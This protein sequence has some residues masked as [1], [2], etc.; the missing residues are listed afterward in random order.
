[1]GNKEST[2]IKNQELKCGYYTIENVFTKDI[3][4]KLKTLEEYKTLYLILEH[5]SYSGPMIGGYPSFI[6]NCKD[7]V[8]IQSYI[9]KKYF[10]NC[11]FHT[12]YDKNKLI[13][14]I[15]MINDYLI[16]CIGGIYSLKIHNE[17]LYK[18]YIKL[19]DDGEEYD[20]EKSFDE[21]NK[22]LKKNIKLEKIRKLGDMLIKLGND[23]H[24]AENN[25]G[26]KILHP[27]F[28]AVKSAIDEYIKG[29]KY[30]YKSIINEN[31]ELY[32]ENE[33]LEN[34]I[35]ELRERYD[36]LIGELRRYQYQK[37]REKDE[38]DEEDEKNEEDEED[39]KDEDDE[40]DEKDE[41]DEKDGYKKIQNMINAAN[42]ELFKKLFEKGVE[43]IKSPEIIEIV[44]KKTTDGYKKIQLMLTMANKKLF[45]KIQIELDKK[46]EN[47]ALQTKCDTLEEENAK[48][49]ERVKI[50]DESNF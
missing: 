35:G 31:Y 25:M 23:S 28:S 36:K 42:E 47:K 13:E 8:S 19:E 18:K 38:E 22:K 44:K 24:I 21:V 45:E 41:E 49:R 26:L 6:K 30:E 17:E 34:K 9:I 11:R 48:L 39:E 16:Y 10:N 14:K 3:T 15:N 7:I 33:Q 32:I 43:T 1:M 12:P 50:L 5:D 20:E 2:P 4:D 37:L 40:D 27:N 29:S 46:D